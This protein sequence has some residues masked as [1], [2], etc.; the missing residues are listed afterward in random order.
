MRDDLFSMYIESKREYDKFI[1]TRYRLDKK[2]G[3]PYTPRKYQ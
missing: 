1:L 3:T 2:I